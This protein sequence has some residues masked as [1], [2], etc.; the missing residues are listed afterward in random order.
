MLE[1]IIVLLLLGLFFGLLIG[2][3]RRLGKTPLDHIAAIA[4]I[5]ATAPEGSAARKLLAEDLAKKAD[6]EKK[7]RGLGIALGIFF[8]VV[9]LLAH[10]SETPTQQTNASVEHAPSA[11][12][13]DVPKG[14]SAMICSAT[15][16]W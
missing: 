9:Y 10:P 16:C 11:F 1:L 7:R 14:G 4:A 3:F 12:S 6:A 2:I 13:S 15:T 5:E 8:L